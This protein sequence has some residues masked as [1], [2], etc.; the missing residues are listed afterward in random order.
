[1][2]SESHP[3][4]E[5]KGYTAKLMEKLDEHLLET[6][7]IDVFINVYDLLAENDYGKF[8]TITINLTF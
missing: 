7:G 6:E 5:W 8:P 2:S 3:H 4:N 1:V